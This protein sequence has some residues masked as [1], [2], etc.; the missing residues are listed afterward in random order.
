MVGAG[1][2]DHDQHGPDKPAWATWK[3]IRLERVKPG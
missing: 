3:N 1:L 2:T